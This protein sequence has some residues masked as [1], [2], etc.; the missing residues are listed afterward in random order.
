MNAWLNSKSSLTDLNSPERKMCRPEKFLIN[1]WLEDRH[2]A[3]K[4]I[5]I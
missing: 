5:F 2:V 1:Q 3:S 4:F